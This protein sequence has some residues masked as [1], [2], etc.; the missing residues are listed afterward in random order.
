MADTKLTALT[1]LAATPASGDLAY[2]VDV[3]D[4]TDGSNGTSKKITRTNLIGGLAASG[5]NSDITSLTGL[6]TALTV[7]QGGSGVATLTG[8]LKGNGTSAFTAVTAPSGAIVGDTD[9]QT[10][11]GKTLTAPK[12]ATGGFI[13]D[14]N[15]NEL[16]IFTTTASALNEWTFANAATG[17]NP[18]LTMSGETNVG[19]DVKMKGTGKFRKPTVVIV[20]VVAAGTNTATG[21]AKAFFTIPE[22]LNGMNLTG[23]G[24]TVYTA[25]TTNTTDI[26]IRNKTDIADMLSTKITIDSTE[27]DSSTAAVAAVINAAT[28]DV[29]TGDVIAIDVDAVSTTAAQGLV[30]KLRFE[31]P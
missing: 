17:A 7:A 29:V 11:S 16:H 21:D 26:Q 28:D 20:P 13:A 22:E 25:G 31:L 12:F 1:E 8:I 9:T 10:L 14:A 27:T 24:A 3:S 19:W 5:A 2:I 18:T 30:V 4:T 6:T 15:G 23:V